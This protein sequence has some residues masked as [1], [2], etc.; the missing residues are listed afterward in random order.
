[1]SIN[2]DNPFAQRCLPKR[3]DKPEP[4]SEKAKRQHAIRQRIAQLEEEKAW[5]R[6]WGAESLL[7]SENENRDHE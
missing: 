3:N 2:S 1:M 4:V 6:E 7:S 5:D